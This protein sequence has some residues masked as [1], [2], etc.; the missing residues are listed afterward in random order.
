MTGSNTKTKLRATFL[1]A[2]MILSVVGGTV[3][4]SGAAVAADP[5]VDVNEITAGGTDVAINDSQKPSEQFVSPGDSVTLNYSIDPANSNESI[6]SATVTFEAVND[7][8]VVQRDVTADSVTERH[9]DVETPSE[10]GFY[11]VTLEATDEKGATDSTSVTANNK[12]GFLAVHT[13]DP[14]VNVLSPDDGSFGSYPVIEG[15]AFDGA[16]I[17]NVTLTIENES[18]DYWNDTSGAWEDSEVAFEVDS[19]TA[20]QTYG[21]TVSWSYDVYDHKDKFDAGEYTIT[22]NAYD[23]QGN[24]LS[25]AKNQG[26]P[27]TD[28]DEDTAP[29][30]IDFELAPEPPQITEIEFLE[31]D[32][33]TA[34]DSIREGNDLDVNVTVDPR[35]TNTDSIEN[36]A[37]ESSALGI[38]S[39][40]LDE[41]T[42]YDD[43]DKLRYQGTVTIDDPSAS[44]GL[45]DVTASVEASGGE[46]TVTRDDTIELIREPDGVQDFSVDAEF[47]GFVKDDASEIDMSI[48]GIVDETGNPVDVDGS[49][50]LN[51]TVGGEVVASGI[52][53]TYGE[54]DNPGS[55]AI[56]PAND[57]SAG[58]QSPGE[59][60][61]EVVYNDSDG[62]ETVLEEFNVELVHEAYGLES[63]QYQPVGT[64]M[65]ATDVS[66][67]STDVPNVITWDPAADGG[68][69]TW[70]TDFDETRAGAGYFVYTEDS[71]A[72]IGYTFETG[73]ATASDET[74]EGG[75][76]DS[77]F[78]L[79]GA[80]PVLQ[81]NSSI[82]IED[83]LKGGEASSVDT[84]KVTA[85][86]DA[87]WIG[88]DENG[89]SIDWTEDGD[90][91][92]EVNQFEAYW[93]EVDAGE[94][95]I[96]A[97][98][99]DGYEPA[100]R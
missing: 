13:E 35:G 43:G 45:V 51:V 58:Q 10:E 66:I 55:V 61:V 21:Q 27:S 59:T 7:N 22:A 30:S 57:L 38:G 84:D 86:H 17:Q 52:T 14:T 75:S 80:T 89:G 88:P 2:V 37:I 25:D 70:T 83:D 63:D 69:G 92:N 91:S 94:E 32:L 68:N 62:T 48:G 5:S 73:S 15:T 93:V 39:A 40:S 29:T 19:Y 34:T 36:A 56:Y 81:D 95:L 23:G 79:V 1:A 82:S 65:P 85:Y 33:T 42:S 100:S 6:T 71:D 74:L 24:T 8:T 4:F 26:P 53:V 31:S 67:D 28:N 96:R 41:V 12:D 11:E 99:T 50:D 76:G 16:G 78:H 9:E 64:P 18:G 98:E 60:T 90:I 3:A 20:D 87:P 49:E 97:F 72:R 46:I 77:Q 47:V 44:G 54:V